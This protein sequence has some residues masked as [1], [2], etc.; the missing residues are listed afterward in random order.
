MYLLCSWH[1]TGTVR[2]YT[3]SYDIVSYLAM[4]MFSI[5]WCG[6]VVS[7]VFRKRSKRDSLQ[8]DIYTV[9]IPS[10]EVNA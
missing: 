5:G 6:F 9:E 4:I 8:T 1:I 2:D 10:I 3:G 7:L